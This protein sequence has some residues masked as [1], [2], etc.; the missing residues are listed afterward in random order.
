MNTCLT[1][2]IL[3]TTLAVI[4]VEVQL[5]ICFSFGVAEVIYP[6]NALSNYGSFPW[7]SPFVPFSEHSVAEPCIL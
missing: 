3:K 2:S 7:N 5:R 6:R 1:T 4:S